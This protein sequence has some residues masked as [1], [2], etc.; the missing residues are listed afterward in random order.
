MLPNY[1]QALPQFLVSFA[2]GALL[3]GVFTSLYT[4]MTKHE[5]F[6]LIRSGNSSA[7][8]MLVGA[9]SGFLLPLCKGLA[10]QV[11]HMALVQWAVVAMLVQLGVYALLR[12]LLPSLHDDIEED[13]VSMALLAGFLS[14]AAGWINASAMP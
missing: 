12:L 10:Q 4:W 14:V 2:L 6:A 1:L 8:L 7:T 11:T 13:R 5:E 9:L 3:L